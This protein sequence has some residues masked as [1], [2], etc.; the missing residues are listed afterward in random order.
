[1]A[2]RFSTPVYNRLCKAGWYE[3]R[4]VPK[5]A[6]PWIDALIQTGY[7]PSQYGQ[8]VLLE[9]G[10]IEIPEEK[11]GINCATMPFWMNP[12]ESLYDQI[13][14]YQYYERWLGKS[15]FPV[16]E[17]FGGESFLAVSEDEKVYYVGAWLIYSGAH[18]EEALTAMILGIKQEHH[19]LVRLSEL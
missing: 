19:I 4:Q 5:L 18:I 6:F 17:V 12:E 8:K 15:L 3:G 11:P 7:R 16:G 1:M 14:V 10:G 2:V 13:E 9:F